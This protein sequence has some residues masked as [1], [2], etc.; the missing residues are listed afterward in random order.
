MR[1]EYNY[2]HCLIKK[3]DMKTYYDNMVK[4]EDTPLRFPSYKNGDCVQ[5]PVASMPDDQA[6]RE[7]KLHTLGDMRWNDNHQRP[8]KYW[9]RDIIKSMR[10]LMR[11]LAYAE[12]LIYAPQHCFNSDTPPKGHYTEIHTADCWWETQGSRDTRE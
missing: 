11:Q 9:S 1:E 6:L 5:M 8:I 4:E 2:S 10:W 3:K 7:C 12:H